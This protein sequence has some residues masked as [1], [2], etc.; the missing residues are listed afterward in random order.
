MKKKNVAHVASKIIIDILIIL[1]IVGVVTVPIWPRLNNMWYFTMALL[2]VTGAVG[3]YI[4]ITLRCM[5]K[6]LLSGNPFVE[7][8]VK[9]FFRM[10]V[11]CAVIAVC[12]IVKCFVVF[13]FGTAIV[14]IVFV[15]ASL[16]CTTLGDLFRKAVEYKQENDWTV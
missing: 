12:Y 2:M 14:A 11:S 8:N 4:L 10:A 1:G 3:V 6:T 13:S 9:A 5:Y 15:I 7:S 16:F